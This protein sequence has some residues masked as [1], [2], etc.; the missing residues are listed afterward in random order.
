MLKSILRILGRSLI[1]LLA[2]V[3]VCSAAY[4]LSKVSG[5]S[6]TRFRSEEGQR[7]EP[8]GTSNQNGQTTRPPRREGGEEGFRGNGSITRGLMQVFV[9]ILLLTAFTWIGLI[10]FNFGKNRKSTDSP[11]P[12]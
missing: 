3:I 7:F 8:Q 5:S 11:E 6:N 12:G 2:A 4:G 1:I 9:N 10:L